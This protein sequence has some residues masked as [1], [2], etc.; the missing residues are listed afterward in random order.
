MERQNL[1]IDIFAGCGGLSLGLCNAGW[2]GLFAIEKNIDA[3]STLHHN[4]ITNN[5]HFLWPDWLPISEH[6]IDEILEKYKSELEALQ[7]SV[8][9]V[10]GGPPCQG[11]SMAGKRDENDKRNHLVNSYIKF[12]DLVRPKAI[13][14]ENVYGF[15]LKFNSKSGDSKKYS[16]I[17][18]SELEKIGYKINSKII[19]MFDY[20]I[21]QK[22]KRFIMIGML[23]NS[24]VS[25]FDELE[26][27]IKSFLTDRN[28]NSYVTIYDAIGDLEKKHGEVQSPDTKKFMAGIYGKIN[29]SY[30]R[31]MRKGIDGNELKAVD[32]H[33]FVNHTSD[34]VSLHEEL[35]KVAPRGKRITPNDNI[36]S[37][38]NKRGVTVLD[39]DLPVPTITS[40][41]DDF[42]HY[43]EPRILTVR[44]HARLQS[45]PDW[46]E[47]KGKY[48]TG[49]ER[50]KIDVPRYT[51]VGNAV[52]PLFS[53]QIGLI[54]KEI[55]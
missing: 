9:L 44:E 42:L 51:Q 25:I 20:G 49:G 11:F 53:E 39:S 10:A 38:M 2:T 54:L 29:S 52:P 34:I 31:F 46:Y 13:I 55:I 18:E 16:N 4:L 47:F 15:T 17:V 45:F 48:T 6:D 37:N 28:L 3:F 30:Q 12:I 26:S 8:D 43:S 19:D 7:G 22:R 36:C 32:S 23:D 24:N 50:R 27:N 33:R 1:Y 35:L 41:P 14:F 5:N 21:P 40:I